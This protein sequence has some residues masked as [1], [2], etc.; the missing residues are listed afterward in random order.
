MKILVTGGAGYVGSHTVRELLD[1][2]HHVTVLDT[3][4]KGHLRACRGAE[5]VMGDTADREL[6]GAILEQRSI[7]CVMHF[8]AYIEVG[9]SMVA[10]ERYFAN[11]T[12]ATA[13]LVQTCMAKKVRRFIFSS[14]CAVYGTPDRLPL[15]E[16]MPKRPE[17]AYGHSKWQTE[18]M[19]GWVSRQTDFRYVALRY[20]NA[21]GAHHSGLLGEAH[22]PESH[23]IPLVLQVAQGTRPNIRIFGTDYPT[24][25]GTCIRDYIHVSDLARAHVAAARYLAN[26]GPSAAFNVGTGNGYSVREIIETCRRITGHAIPAVEEARRP[27]DPAEL[28]AN[29]AKIRADL[30]WKPVESD[31]DTIIRSAW[32]WHSNNPNGYVRAD[33][34]A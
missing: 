3:L 4:E 15:V 21:C 5:F 31:L 8:A 2:G 10:P 6:V 33:R 16:D 23:L 34:G 9:E 20:F 26:G 30:D 24:K 12:A 29:P 22:S 32:N 11:N 25:D 17:S 28:Y 27:G 14:T 7:E 19:L 13:R 18:E 1:A